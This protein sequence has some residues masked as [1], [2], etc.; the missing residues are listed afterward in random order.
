MVHLWLVRGRAALLPASGGER[1]AVAST[2]PTDAMTEL[3]ELG[4][5][6]GD[7]DALSPTESARYEELAA[8]ADVATV[9]VMISPVS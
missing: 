4:R 7:G 2:L 8:A 9:A 3:E 6:I 5:R 1:V